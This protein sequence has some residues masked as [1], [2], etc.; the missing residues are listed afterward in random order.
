MESSAAAPGSGPPIW[1]GGGP[2]VPRDIL[3]PLF[4]NM[5]L[6]PKRCFHDSFTRNAD[7]LTASWAKLTMDER[8]ALHDFITEVAQFISPIHPQ[9]VPQWTV[10]NPT[11][12]WLHDNRIWLELTLLLTSVAAKDIGTLPEHAFAI[13]AG[14][15]S[16]CYDRGVFE[17]LAKSRVEWELLFKHQYA[18]WEACTIKRKP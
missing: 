14:V 17:R 1:D 9:G 12:I 13:C 11:L 7:R 2:R 15:L 18:F 10:S 5:T 6:E 8:W 16:S 3:W 4:K